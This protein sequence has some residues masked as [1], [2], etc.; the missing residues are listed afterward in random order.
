MGDLARVQVATFPLLHK[1]GH[2]TTVRQGSLKKLLQGIKIPNSQNK[3]MYAKQEI[4]Y[5]LDEMPTDF[6]VP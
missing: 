2:H 3:T 5:T 6:V 4:M 1:G